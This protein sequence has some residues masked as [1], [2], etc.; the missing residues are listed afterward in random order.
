M[1]QT[2][3]IRLLTDIGFTPSEIAE[4]TGLEVEEVFAT[5]VA[6][7]IMRR[8]EDGSNSNTKG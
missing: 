1:T 5:M 3:M 8:V 6:N 4:R 2:Q 7:L